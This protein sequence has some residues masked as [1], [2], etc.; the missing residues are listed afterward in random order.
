MNTIPEDDNHIRYVKK[1]L[2][3]LNESTVLHSSDVNMD[4]TVV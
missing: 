4:E 1:H 2:R 3:T